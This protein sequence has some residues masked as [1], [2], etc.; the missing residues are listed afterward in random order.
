MVP[1]NSKQDRYKRSREMLSRAQKSL[2]GGVSSPFRAKH[3]L[4]LYFKDG[5]GSRLTDVDGNEYIDYSLAWGPLILGH[6]HP[7]IV[8]AI[9]RQADQPHIY[10]AQHELEFEVSE[11]I[12]KLVP[13]AERLVFTSSGSEAVQI[14][15]RLARAYT[16]RPLILKFEG[17]YHGWMDS[18]L[19][20]Y[21]PSKGELSPTHAPVLGSRGQ[22]ENSL[23]NVLVIEWNNP[24]AVQRAFAE[25]GPRIAA[26]VTEPVLCNSGC[27][28]PKPGYLEFLRSIAHG[29]GSLLIFDEVITG[30]RMSP[31]GAQQAIGVT[32]D[33]CTLGKAIAGGLPLSAIAGKSDIMELMV[34]GGVVFGGTYNGNPLSLAACKVTLEELSKDDGA[35]LVYARKLG[36]ELMQ[37]FQSFSTTT[38]IPIQLTGFGT[39]FSVHFGN[40]AKLENYRDTLAGDTALLRAFIL[41]ALDAGLYLLPDGRWYLSTAHT[42]DDIADTK[43]RVVEALSKLEVLQQA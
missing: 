17:H 2:A 37:T 28:M 42:A 32:P 29:N 25:H 1:I 26:V 19:I 9:H 16:N 3:P 6:R 36:T 15:L 11:L 5:S 43:S 41:S 38:G 39:A 8:K 40:K 20:S 27:V 22:V 14:A 33:I 4:P 23:D 24:E 30:F 21:H 12:Q 10:G 18:A 34:S 7:E 35:S 13:C 31:G